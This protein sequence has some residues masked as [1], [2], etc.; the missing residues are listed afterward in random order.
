MVGLSALILSIGLVIFVV[1]LARWQFRQE[2]DI[3]DILFQ[4]PVRGLNQGRRGP[5]QRHQGGR[6]H[7]DR[8]RPHQPQPGDRPGPGHLRRADQGRQ[9]RHPGAAGHH[10]RQLHPDHRRHPVQA[11]AQGRHRAQGRQDPDH[12]QPAQRALR[13]AGGR[14][15]RADPHHR[16][17]GPGQPRAL[18]PEHQELLGRWSPTP[19]PSRPSCA[20][21]RR[22]SPTPRAPCSGSTRPPP[23]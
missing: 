2:N 14:R 22:S 19:R 6:G 13:P 10:R 5:L 20:S 11:A 9:L 18:R 16:G 23:S 1:W 8:A 7:Q 12:P 3:Y 17:A 15:H 21:A 4:G